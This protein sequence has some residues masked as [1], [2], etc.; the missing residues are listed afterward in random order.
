MTQRSNSTVRIHDV[1]EK[2]TT[3]PQ[4]EGL[5]LCEVEEGS[6]QFMIPGSFFSTASSLKRGGGDAKRGT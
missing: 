3:Q 5:D 1:H 4:T 2:S 6:R